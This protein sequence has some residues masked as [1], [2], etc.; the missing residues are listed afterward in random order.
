MKTMN[1]EFSGGSVNQT[2]TFTTKD[3][4]SIP[5]QQDQK[6]EEQGDELYS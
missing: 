1:G 4:G 6:K 3:R 5:S 2:Y